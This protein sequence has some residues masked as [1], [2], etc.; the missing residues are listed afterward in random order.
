MA[1]AWA[2][3]REIL[4]THSKSFDWAARLLP[5][6]QRDEIAALYAWCRLCDDA[7]DLTERDRH[8][9]ELARLR[10]ELA[11]V[12][13]GEPQHEPVLSCFAQV[14]ARR[15]VPIEYPT[16]LLDGMEMDARA[17]CYETLDDLLVYCWRV[18][19]SVGLMLCHVLGIS[20]A[21]A[22]RNAAHLGIAM[23]LTN[24]ARDV[25]EDWQRGR[26]YLPLASLGPE[27]RAWIEANRSE[28]PAPFPAN[29][30]P[31]L[32]RATRSLLQ[33]AESYYASADVGLAALEPRAALAI[34]AARL[35][36]AEIGRVLEARK[37][38]VLPG[39]VAVKRRRKASLTAK[40]VFQFAGD[41]TRWHDRLVSAPCGVLDEREA[42][43]LP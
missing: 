28:A 31:D 30:G 16:A 34:R 25:A 10:K 26:V 8:E 3:C 42:I 21:S 1:D 35:I 15:G 24:I 4:A 14:V 27:L 20:E 13:A 41:R 36:Y 29:H 32:A 23:Q 22:S 2:A 6:T 39:R 5:R 38:D 37:C 18:A 9:A 17:A 43:R 12:Y 19:G 40:A 7:I 33:S 11:S